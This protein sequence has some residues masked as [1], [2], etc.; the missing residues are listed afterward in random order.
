LF[1][2]AKW[3]TNDVPDEQPATKRA[4]ADKGTVTETATARKRSG[5]RKQ[6]LGLIVT[7]PIDILLE[8]K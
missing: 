4:R 1:I 3:V 5:K 8:V 7:V 6:S 2:R